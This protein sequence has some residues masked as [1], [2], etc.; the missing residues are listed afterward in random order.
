MLTLSSGKFKGRRL[1]SVEGKDVR[2][3]L[4]KVRQA[5]FNILTNLI[6]IEDYEIIDLFAGTGA[7]GL[8]AIS[9][10]A[11]FAF[12]IENKAKHCQCIKKNISELK[13]EKQT[14]IAC[15]EAFSWLRQRS[16]QPGDRLFFLDPP[17]NKEALPKLLAYFAKERELFRN[18][19][20]VIEMDKKEEIQYPEP[21]ALIRQKI[22]GGTRIDFLQI[23][24]GEPL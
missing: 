22:Y 12:F 9:R 6:Q 17:Y 10:G 1:H 21:F 4:G 5:I 13:L 11:P 19:L 14:A 23:I 8:E 20:F 18:N 24:P 3:T 2:P 16:W 15:K 7:L